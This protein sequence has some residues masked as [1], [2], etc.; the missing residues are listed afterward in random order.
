[1]YTANFHHH[2]GDYMNWFYSAGKCHYQEGNN[3]DTEQQIFILN[4]ISLF[5][6][7]HWYIYKYQNTDLL[8]V[9][10]LYNKHW[11]FQHAYSKLWWLVI[12]PW[13]QPEFQV[14]KS[15]MKINRNKYLVLSWLKAYFIDRS[16]RHSTLYINLL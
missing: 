16:V 1:M 7:N 10:R 13:F 2:F 15:L 5:Q 8:T 12:S 3:N 4:L 6:F 9:F 11:S 14:I